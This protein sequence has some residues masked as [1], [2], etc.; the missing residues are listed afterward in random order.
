MSKSNQ[1]LLLRID[2]SMNLI[3]DFLLKSKLKITINEVE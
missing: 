3:I 2:P 1:Q